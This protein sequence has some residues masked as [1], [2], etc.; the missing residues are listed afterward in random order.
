M[1]SSHDKHNLYRM[2][3]AF[4]YYFL[5][6]YY[7]DFSRSDLRKHSTFHRQETPRPREAK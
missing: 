7:L 1:F 4:L 6:E 3:A 5:K 2:L